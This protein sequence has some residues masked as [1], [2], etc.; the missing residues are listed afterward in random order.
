MLKFANG[1]SL[2]SYRLLLSGLNALVGNVVFPH[3]NLCSP[4]SEGPLF[5][6]F[7]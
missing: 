3:G 1:G 4:T 2:V 5:P 6:A 7:L